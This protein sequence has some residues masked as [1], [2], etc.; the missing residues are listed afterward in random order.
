MTIPLRKKHT[1]EILEGKF[2]HSFLTGLISAGDVITE[3]IIK[4]HPKL[5]SISMHREV[6]LGEG[7]RVYIELEID[8]N[9]EHP[10]DQAQFLKIYKNL[11]EEHGLCVDTGLWERVKVRVL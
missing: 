11:C 4:R 5:I 7:R 6:S 2:V 8:R 1:I 3:D 9:P 10:H